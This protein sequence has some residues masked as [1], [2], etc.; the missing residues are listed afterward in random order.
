MKKD[1]IATV[2][3]AWQDAGI[4]ALVWDRAASHRARL[5]REVE[6]TLITQ[7]PAAPELNPPSASL[8]SYAAP[9]RAAP[10]PAWPTRS[11]PSSADS[12]P[13]PP[14]PLASAASPA[15][16]GFRMPSL[17]PFRPHLEQLV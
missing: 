11:P 17:N 10:T 14:I 2:V 15:R 16:P 4:A 9:S 12:S 1:A 3:S 13:S 6:M 5:V 7:P 8:R